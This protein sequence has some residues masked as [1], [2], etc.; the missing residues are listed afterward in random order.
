[1]SLIGY[2]P[3]VDGQAWLPPLVHPLNCTLLA[4]AQGPLSVVTC[5]NHLSQMRTTSVATCGVCGHIVVVVGAVQAHCCCCCRGL[6][7][8]SL[9]LCNFLHLHCVSIYRK[10]AWLKTIK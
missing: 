4:R 10:A 2:S 9:S 7:A 1:M 5:A 8:Q 6:H 3:L